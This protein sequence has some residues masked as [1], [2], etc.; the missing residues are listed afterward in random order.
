[1]IEWT[2]MGLLIITWR[3]LWIVALLIF[4]LGI[5]ASIIPA[6]V[7]QALDM[8]DREKHDLSDRS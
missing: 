6:F 3:G 4:W 8:Q 1:M 2:P 7:I 5:G